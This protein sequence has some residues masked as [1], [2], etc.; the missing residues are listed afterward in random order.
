MPGSLPFELRLHLGGHV[1]AVAV[2]FERFAHHPLVASVHVAARRVNIVD[3]LLSKAAWKIAGSL[4]R[5]AP[6]LTM[7]IF[8]PVRP[9]VRNAGVPS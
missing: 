8:I 2:A 7:V 6:M 4:V 9:S 1:H 5:M 3:P